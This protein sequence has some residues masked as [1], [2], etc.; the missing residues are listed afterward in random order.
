M[1]GAAC[2]APGANI[3]A[4]ERASTALV[5]R[6]G[7]QAVRNER[8]VESWAACK[9]SAI[10]D[11]AAAAGGGGR[12]SGELFS[13]AVVA[14]RGGCASAGF[15]GTTGN[16]CGGAR[17]FCTRIDKGAVDG[18]I[19][20]SATTAAAV[21]SS[22]R[23]VGKPMMMSSSSSSSVSSSSRYL[24]GPC[25]RMNLFTAVNAAIR[26]AMETDPTAVRSATAFHL[27]PRNHGQMF[28]CPYS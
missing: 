21:A 18:A 25:T 7:S 1:L 12:A 8:T 2:R 17:S 4:A 15:R 20:S 6:A 9:S 26:T 13:R 5:A 24:D 23:G 28:P 22:A 3:G 14:C 16:W 11:G 27:S 10:P 19:A